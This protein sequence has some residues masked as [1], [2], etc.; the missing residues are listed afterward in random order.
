M[1]YRLKKKLYNYLTV[2]PNTELKHICVYVL[3]SHQH[4]GFVDKKT[5]KE[6]NPHFKSQA[7]LA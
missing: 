1:N 3:N 5:Q 6:E 7:F 2:T 4:L